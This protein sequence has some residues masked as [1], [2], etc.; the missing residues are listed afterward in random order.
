MRVEMSASARTRLSQVSELMDM[1]AVIAW[2][3]TTYFAEYANISALFRSKKSVKKIIVESLY[4]TL[5]LLNIKK[6]VFNLNI[7]EH[8]NAIVAQSLGL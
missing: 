4:F 3:Q 7:R 6:I 2:S 5:E 1:K 8:F